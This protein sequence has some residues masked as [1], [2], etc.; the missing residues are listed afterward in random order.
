MRHHWQTFDSDVEDQLRVGQ[1]D[2]FEAG[3]NLQGMRTLPKA[4]EKEFLHL[5]SAHL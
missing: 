4:S 5:M 3:H 2:D 1:P